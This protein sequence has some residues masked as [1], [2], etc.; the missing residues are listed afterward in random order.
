MFRRLANGSFELIV[1]PWDSDFARSWWQASAQRQTIFRLGTVAIN[2][3]VGL[4]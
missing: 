3:I 4:L 1:T 2:R